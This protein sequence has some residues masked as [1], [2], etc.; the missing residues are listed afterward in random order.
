MMSTVYPG[1]RI[2]TGGGYRI[3]Q[4][5]SYLANIFFPYT[6]SITNVCEPSSYIYPFTGLIILLIYNIANIK[7]R[8]KK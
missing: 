8:K 2:I 4:F 3:D 7:K 6:H 5:I 1:K